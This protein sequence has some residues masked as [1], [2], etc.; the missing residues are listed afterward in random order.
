MSAT[1]LGIYNGALKLC[2]E[3][4]LASLTEA[5]EPRYLLDDVWN[6]DGV[7]ACLEAG[8]W[9]FAMRTQRVDYE[10]SIQPAFG[11]QRA[12]TKPEDWCCTSAVCEDE[13]FRVPLTQ[14]TDEAGYWFS[15]RD[16]IFVKYVSNATDYGGSLARWPQAFVN[17]VESYFA[18]KICRKLTSAADIVD[19]LLHPRTGLVASARLAAQNANAMALPTKFPAQGTWV[20]SRRGQRRQRDGGNTG[21]LIG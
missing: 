21:Q 20:R 10:P 7:K 11:Y 18:S 12:F 19:A 4:K 1:R 17:Y 8:Q 15:D 13:Y 2:G 9:F 6:D 16:Q 3:R 5:R 14:H